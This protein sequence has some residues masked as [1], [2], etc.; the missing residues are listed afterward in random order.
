MSSTLGIIVALPTEAAILTKQPVKQHIPIILSD[1]VIL[2]VCG[3]GT[4]NAKQAAQL[5]LKKGITSLLS[6]GTAGGLN[7]ERLPGDIIVANSCINSNGDIFPVDSNWQQ[8]IINCLLKSLNVSSAAICESTKVIA[9]ST[10]KQK[11]FQSNN[12]AAVDMESAALAQLAKEHIIPF[13]SIRVIVDPA[14]MT[15]P[16]TVM[17]NMD[18]NGN[19]AITK[20]LFGLLK[21]PGDITSLIRLAKNFNKAQKEMIKCKNILGIGFLIV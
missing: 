21:K 1:T 3:M 16:F 18:D 15:I 4:A 9:N 8:R 10:D 19:V 13:I 7:P 5:L 12:A 2:I 17:N 20:L 11:L 14:N 6:F